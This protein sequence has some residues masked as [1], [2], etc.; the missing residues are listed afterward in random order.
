MLLNAWLQSALSAV[1]SLD[2][3]SR[4][5]CSMARVPA[6]AARL[7]LLSALA[8]CADWEGG[9]CAAGAE[10][11]G[12]ACTPEGPKTGFASGCVGAVG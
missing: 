12:M 8:G 11:L 1:D 2:R 10:V 6:A 9:V 3:A 4:A 5:V 7:L